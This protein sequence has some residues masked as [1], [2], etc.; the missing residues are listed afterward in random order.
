[1]KPGAA[2]FPW[3]D[4]LL[5]VVL[6][7]ATAFAFNWQFIPHSNLAHLK[8]T[9]D[10]ESIIAGYRLAQP[11]FPASLAWWHGPWIQVGIPAFR[12]I[13][14]YLYWFECHIG[15]TWGFI[16]VGWLGFALFVANCLLAA[17]LAWRFTQS[18]LLAFFAAVL[19]TAVRFYNPLQND[20][21]LKWFPAHQ[22]LLM[23]ALMLGAVSCFAVWLEN[24]RRRYIVGAWLLFVA[25]CLAKEHVYI[26]PLMALGLALAYRQCRTVATGRAA[27]HCALMIVALIG[28]WQYR[29]QVITNPRNPTIVAGQLVQKPLL[30]MY[31]VFGRRVINAEMMTKT[32]EKTTSGNPVPPRRQPGFW[33]MMATSDAWFAGLN[34]LF[35]TVGGL[36]LRMRTWRFNGKAWLLWSERPYLWV[37]AALLVTWLYLLAVGHPVTEVIWLYLEKP[38]EQPNWRDTIYMQAILYNTYLL[39]KYRKVEPTLAIWLLWGLSYAPVIDFSGWHY[40]LPAWFVRCAYYALQGRLI[41]I[42]LGMPGRKWLLPEAGPPRLRE[43]GEL[44][45]RNTLG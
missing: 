5:L 8:N 12:P 24:G 30:F 3:R 11:L 14:G 4:R 38:L 7:V 28:L 26:F 44:G 27:L 43:A 10:V 16:W 34:V 1:M 35:F 21:W 9:N 22:E 20:D 19:A 32:H 41:W 29:K 42:D 33:E 39:W 37:L 13:S 6:V 15:L 18:R 23:N 25:G 40:T 31:T 17:N 2:V 36:M 45:G